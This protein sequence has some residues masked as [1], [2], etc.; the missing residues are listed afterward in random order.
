MNNNF[1]HLIVFP[2]SVRRL[3]D[4][5]GERIVFL[6]SCCGIWTGGFGRVEGIWTQERIPVRYTSKRIF[7]FVFFVNTIPVTALL[8]V[9]LHGYTRHVVR[10]MDY[11]FSASGIAHVVK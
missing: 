1:G 2:P 5:D 6:L 7:C 10:L 8:F 3:V 9:P 4:T 11:D